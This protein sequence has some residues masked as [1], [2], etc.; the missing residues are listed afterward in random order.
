M[1]LT[2]IH[3]GLNQTICVSDGLELLYLVHEMPVLKVLC[4]EISFLSRGYNVMNLIEDI[5]YC[6]KYL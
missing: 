3:N 6:D 2:A 4:Y 5:I 1:R